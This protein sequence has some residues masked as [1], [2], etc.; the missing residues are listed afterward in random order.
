[1]RILSLNCRGL[2]IPEAIQELHCLISE[3]DPKV[4]FLSETKLDRDDFRRL[5][6]KINFQNG[7][8]VPRIG[9]GAGL[10]LLWW[11]NMDVDVQK[12][13]PHHIDGLIN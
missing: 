5:K 7:F 2:G 9:L 1:M 4:L 11:D 6:R 3:E 13:S 12:S 8:E 10:A